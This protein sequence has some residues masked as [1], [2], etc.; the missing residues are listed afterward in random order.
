MTSEGSRSADICK[1]CNGTGIC[2][3][4][5]LE[6]N[7]CHCFGV[8]TKLPPYRKYNDQDMSMTEKEI[9]TC[10]GCLKQLQ[11]FDIEEEIEG[12]E[13]YVM[14]RNDG[15]G[16]EDVYCAACWQDKTK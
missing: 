11:M 9:I 15:S 2:K 12:D 4:G 14:S 1:H 13:M 10:S 8:G 7:C 6:S 5:K 3:L 16:E